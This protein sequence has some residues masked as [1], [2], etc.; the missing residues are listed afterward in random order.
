MKVYISQ[1]GE[2]EDVFEMR[3]WKNEKEAQYYV[4]A[5]EK[6]IRD[7]DPKRYEYSLW[8]DVEGPFE[9]E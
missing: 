1:I 5:K 3:V 6:E 2:W 8:S 9:V 4:A 7:K